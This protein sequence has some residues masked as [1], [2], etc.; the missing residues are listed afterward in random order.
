MR[1]A[2]SFVL[3]GG[4]AALA[5]PACSSTGGFPADALRLCALT[6]G[7]TPE[8]AAGGFGFMCSNIVM[9][10]AFAPPAGMS[11]SG[12]SIPGFPSFACMEQATTCAE[13]SACSAPT[14]ADDAL[15]GGKTGNVCANGVALEG[16]PKPTSVTDCTALG[17][18]CQASASGASCAPVTCDASNALHCEGNT[19]VGCDPMTGSIVDQDCTLPTSYVDSNGGV[20]PYPLVG[21]CVNAQCTGAGAPCTS[22]DPEDYTCQGS[23]I[24]G[25]GNG[26]AATFDCTTLNLGLTCSDQG[27]GAYCIRPNAECDRLAQETCNDGVITFCLFGVT[28]T[29]DCKSYG[30]S[31]CGVLTG[32]PLPAAPFCKN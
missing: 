15:C 1:L 20:Y 4:A 21:A 24:A 29:V 3:L 19:L 17:V 26:H 12:G 16:C 31:G 8:N 6:S 23:V 11:G 2:L 25:C 32:D 18:A 13:L 14:P 30:F 9:A 27:E 28:T 5:V 7:C 10:A 22:I